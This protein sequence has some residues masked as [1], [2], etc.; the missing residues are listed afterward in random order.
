VPLCF[1][2][3]KKRGTCNS[4]H[5]WVTKIVKNLVCRQPS[6]YRSKP[7]SKCYVID[8]FIGTFVDWSEYCALLDA[9]KEL[10]VARNS[11]ENLCELTINEAATWFSEHSV[12]KTSIAAFTRKYCRY[13][14]YRWNFADIILWQHRK[15]CPSISSPKRKCGFM[16]KSDIISCPSMT[17]P[18]F[19]AR[20]D[21]GGSH[22][23]FSNK[24]PLTLLVFCVNANVCTW[25]RRH[26]RSGWFCVLCSLL[27]L[28]GQSH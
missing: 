17:D 1:N 24:R 19:Q 8:W 25:E 22:A 11:T 27:G 28:P 13:T 6:G 16:L 18:F 26:E 7:E 20:C 23:V 3:I 10:H 12:Q 21:T 2:A 4:A 15:I 9:V 5:T 14:V